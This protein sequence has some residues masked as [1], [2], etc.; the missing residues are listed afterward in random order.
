M[1]LVG[2]RGYLAAFYAYPLRKG[3]F[4]V[5]SRVAW[6]LLAVGL[7]LP[8]WCQVPQFTITTAA[9]NGMKGSSGDGGQATNAELDGPRGVTEDIFGNLYIAEYYGQRVQKVTP[10]GTITTI[11]GNGIEGYSGDGGPAT[12]AELNGPYRVTVDIAGN[13]YIPDS[14]NGCIRKVSPDGTISNHSRQRS[15]GLL[16]RWRAGY[17]GIP[18]ISGA[19]GI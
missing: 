13:V 9:G 8:G 12:V 2:L 10:S 18:D 17:P 3:D 7:S 4:N 14:G 1:S 5:I 11:A 6:L 19:G 16:R 15:R